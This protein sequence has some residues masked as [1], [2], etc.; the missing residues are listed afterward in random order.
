LRIGRGEGRD[1]ETDNVGLSCGGGNG[2][3][4]RDH[5]GRRDRAERWIGARGSV[6]RRGDDPP[7]HVGRHLLVAVRR[8]RPLDLVTQQRQAYRQHLAGQ[9]Q[10]G[11]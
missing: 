5:C 9:Q 3:T 6:G 11:D 1:S 2:S 4:K 10:R 8:R 7:R